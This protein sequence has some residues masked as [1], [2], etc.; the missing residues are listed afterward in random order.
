MKFAEALKNMK[1]GIPMK[2]PSW[3]GYWCWDEENQTIIMH[4]KDS[5]TLDI[6]E[7][8]QVEYTLENVLSDAW[9]P[10]SGENTPILGGVATFGFE[11][12][13]KYL[14]RGM[15]VMR[16]G[17][18]GKEMYITLIPA[19]NACFQGFPMQNCFGLKTGNGEMQPGWIPS[20]RDCLADDWMFLD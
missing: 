16:S 14:K 13:L 1:T 8:Q 18:N 4:T 2:L 6:R 11:E 9:I 10:A 20:V 15:K 5:Q 19:G 3:G 17:W 7:T 12:A